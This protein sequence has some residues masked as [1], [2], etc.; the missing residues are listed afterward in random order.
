[1]KVVPAVAA[2]V[3]LRTLARDASIF[4]EYQIHTRRVAVCPARSV[5]LRWPRWNPGPT[6]G[7]QPSVSKQGAGTPGALIFED[8]RA[9]LRGQWPAMAASGGS[10]STQ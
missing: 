8:I 3:L 4:A 1:M 9:R 10:R 5:F 2:M 7:L 6:R